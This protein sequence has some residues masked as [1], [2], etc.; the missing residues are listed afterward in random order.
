MNAIQLEKALRGGPLTPERL[1]KAQKKADSPDVY[2][3]VL[4][5]IQAEQSAQAKANARARED[6]DDGA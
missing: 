2:A 6:E 5:S 1:R 3:A 4:A